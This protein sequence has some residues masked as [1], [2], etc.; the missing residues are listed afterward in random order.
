LFSAASICA[1]L[2]ELGVDVDPTGMAMINHA[3]KTRRKDLNSAK[4]AWCQARAVLHARGAFDDVDMPTEVG[5]SNLLPFLSWDIELFKATLTAR[6]PP[7]DGKGSVLELGW[8]SA[9]S[10][11]LHIFSDPTCWDADAIRAVLRQAGRRVGLEDLVGAPAPAD[12]SVLHLLAAIYGEAVSRTVRSSPTEAPSHTPWQALIREVFATSRGLLASQR[13]PLNEVA[14]V[15][16]W[17]SALRFTSH[18]GKSGLKTPLGCFLVRLFHFA[19]FVPTPMWRKH[20]RASLRY[21]LEDIQDVGF[22][23]AEYGRQELAALKASG[24]CELWYWWQDDFE[25]PVR[26][27]GLRYGPAIEDWSL[28]WDFGVEE[29]AGDFWEV[30]ESTPAVAVTLMPG[31]WVDDD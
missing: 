17:L 5:N 6:W 18:F 4:A 20:I 10:Q 25:R 26:V 14:S 11:A 15:P 28:E 16:T 2:L 31:A 13:P 24:G 12:T 22:D 29:F 1:D 8:L 3:L 30:M 27:A 19:T 7:E 9:L 23:L 21:W